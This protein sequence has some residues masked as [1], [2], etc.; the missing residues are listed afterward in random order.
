MANPI[1][2]WTKDLS[3]IV[4]CWLA[5]SDASGQPS[6]SP[7]ELFIAPD[8]NRLWIAEIASPRSMRN[9]RANPKVCVSILD[10]FAQR[11]HKLYGSAT[12]EDPDSELF[13]TAG[14]A[15]QAKAGDAFT[16][17]HV[18][19]VDVDRALPIVA[20]SYLKTPHPSA[21]DMRAQSYATYGVQPRPKG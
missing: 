6:V 20:P 8:P 3:D 13:Q 10:V 21:D 12:V 17:R 9:I 4:L 15:L 2:D 18:I 19:A 5:T 7:K 14:A 1:P 16:V 11:G